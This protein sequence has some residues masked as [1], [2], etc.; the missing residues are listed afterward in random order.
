MKKEKSLIRRI[1]ESFLRMIL[2]GIKA[3]KYSPLQLAKHIKEGN[4]SPLDK[5]E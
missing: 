1:F 4:Q 5:H 3:N 2:I